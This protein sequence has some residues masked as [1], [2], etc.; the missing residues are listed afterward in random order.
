MPRIKQDPPKILTAAEKATLE[1]LY[2][3]EDLLLDW[4]LEHSSDHPDYPRMIHLLHETGK[5]IVTME[6][7]KALEVNEDF[8]R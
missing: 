4:L 3:K 2:T 5:E 7:G 8:R 1:A 6:G